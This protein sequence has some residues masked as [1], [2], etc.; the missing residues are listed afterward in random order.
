MYFE[1]F[2]PIPF[3]IS[4]AQISLLIFGPKVLYRNGVIYAGRR[5]VSPSLFK[6]FV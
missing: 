4:L 1:V 3:N 6:S 2:R 5:M